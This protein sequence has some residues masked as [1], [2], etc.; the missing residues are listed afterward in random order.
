M[1]SRV[2]F[3]FFG[4]LLLPSF[5]AAQTSSSGTGLI[6]GI[7]GSSQF[8]DG[9]ENVFDYDTGYGI[10][11]QL[12]YRLGQWRAMAEIGYNGSDFR[13]AGNDVFDV[14]IIR[15]D[16]SLFYDF[17]TAAALGN[18]T[19]YLGGGVGAANITVKGTGNSSFED[20]ETG[21]TLH[22]EIGFS[23]GVTESFA[24]VPQYRL[25]WF[26]TGVAGFDENFYAHAFRVAAQLGF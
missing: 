10:G 26:D 20:D 5:G 14:E 22:G 25:E 24:I 3:C 4:I 16:V 2:L 12:G 11:G 21:I 13:D 15:G 7:V 6:V 17:G 9:G 19:P 18:V 8:F 23:V 1:C